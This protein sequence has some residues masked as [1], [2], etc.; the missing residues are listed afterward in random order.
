MKTVEGET[1]VCTYVRTYRVHSRIASLRVSE[2][3]RYGPPA[4]RTLRAIA[5]GVIGESPHGIT[6]LV[7]RTLSDFRSEILLGKPYALP[8]GPY[9][10]LCTSYYLGACRTETWTNSCVNNKEFTPLFEE[11]DRLRL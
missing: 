9:I 10:L 4:S 11:T 2:G 3:V 7:S 8:A 6:V 5:S 1:E